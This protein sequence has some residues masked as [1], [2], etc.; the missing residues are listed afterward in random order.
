MS[1][2]KCQIDSCQKHV[3]YLEFLLVEMVILMFGTVKGSRRFFKAIFLFQAKYD[4][5]Q[6]YL[7]LEQF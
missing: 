6:N 5:F 1:F 2:T 7:P 3:F 4:S